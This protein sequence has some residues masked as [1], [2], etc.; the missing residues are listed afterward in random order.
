MGI[1]ARRADTISLAN[2][3]S[4]PT[5][6]DIY[7]LTSQEIS[8][9]T[10]FFN[11]IENYLKV[12][13]ALITAVS[14]TASKKSKTAAKGASRDTAA[15]QLKCAS[16]ALVT[17]MIQSGLNGRM[18]LLNLYKRLESEIKEDSMFLWEEINDVAMREAM[19]KITAR[20][21]CTATTD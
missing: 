5:G 15:H 12:E 18:N 8:V 14:P 4:S 7:P 13:S 2:P 10:E 17:R 3:G 21:V 19:G 20:E 16:L 1:D 6:G 9:L 11:A